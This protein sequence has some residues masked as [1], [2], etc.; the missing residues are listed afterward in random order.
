MSK[1]LNMDDFGFNEPAALTTVEHDDIADTKALV[2]VESQLQQI[3]DAG[4]TALVEAEKII[5]TDAESADIA[6]ETAKNLKKVEKQLEEARK[7]AVKPFNDIVDKINSTAKRFAGPFKTA[8]LT[9]SNKVIA[10]QNAERLRIAAEQKKLRQEQEAA[11]LANQPVKPQLQVLPKEPPKAISTRVTYEWRCI[12]FEAVPAE[13]KILVLNEEKLNQVVRGQQ[14]KAI[15][16]IEIIKKE[17]P[18][19]R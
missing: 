12:D 17:T 11:L 5:V 16:G 8:A 7:A 3:V 13:Y 18:I 14:V 19:F 2:Q 1:L 6:S 9:L 4:A 10:Y 15:P